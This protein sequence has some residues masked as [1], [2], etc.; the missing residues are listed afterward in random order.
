MA[1]ETV[2]LVE[3]LLSIGIKTNDMR[4]VHHNLLNIIILNAIYV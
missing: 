4:R 1:A 2:D 3:I